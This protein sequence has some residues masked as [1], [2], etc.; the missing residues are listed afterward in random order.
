M[1]GPCVLFSNLQIIVFPGDSAKSRAFVPA[2][3]ESFP[4]WAMLREYNLLPAEKTMKT[5]AE[6]IRVMPQ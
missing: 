4:V 6:I 3:R 5:S 1:S 2:I